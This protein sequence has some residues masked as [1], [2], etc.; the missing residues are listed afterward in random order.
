MRKSRFRPHVERD[1]LGTQAHPWVPTIEITGVM[2]IFVSA[3]SWGMMTEGWKG[4]AYSA[5]GAVV[6][7]YYVKKT[8]GE[9]SAEILKQ[10]RREYYLLQRLR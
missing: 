3:L 6:L 5:I 8:I 10:K 2:V 7:I 1:E 9:M 4:W